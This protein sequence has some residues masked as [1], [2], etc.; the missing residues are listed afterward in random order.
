MESY[1]IV[2]ILLCLVSYAQ[3]SAFDIYPYACISHSLLFIAK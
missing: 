3:D 2:S 1:T